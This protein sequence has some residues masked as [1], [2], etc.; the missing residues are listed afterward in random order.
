MAQGGKQKCT[1]KTAPLFHEER[2]TIRNNSFFRLSGKGLQLYLRGMDCRYVHRSI[3]PLENQALTITPLLDTDFAKLLEAIVP[4]IKLEIY[5]VYVSFFNNF[6]YTAIGGT[7]VHSLWSAIPYL[8]S[9][10]HLLLW[11]K[12]GKWKT[13]KRRKRKRTWKRKRT[14]KRTRNFT[15]IAK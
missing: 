10:I 7:I 6:S 11:Y 1:K 5:H 13:R 9:A 2:S 15:V 14:G 8:W 12:M 4:L 3:K